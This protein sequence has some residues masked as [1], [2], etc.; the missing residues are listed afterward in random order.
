MAIQG[1]DYETIH[2]MVGTTEFPSELVEEY[3]VRI[4]MLVI[5][6]GGY[7]L[8]PI[9]CVDLCRFVG[10]QSKTAKKELHYI[11]WPLVKIDADIVVTEH[12][13][14]R[15]GKYRGSVQAGRII[16]K[17]ADLDWLSEAVATNV[18]LAVT[19][20]F[21]PKVDTESPS[22]IVAEMNS[23]KDC[24]PSM[25]IRWSMVEV[26]TPVETMAGD[27]VIEYEYLGLAKEKGCLAVQDKVTKHRYVLDAADVFLKQAEPVEV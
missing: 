25:K 15:L 26:G 4:R 14:D 16:V 10:L 11:D 5:A 7:S 8:G 6:G 20:D 21:L 17:F 3:D 22:A 13:V 19:D 24:D 9:G 18:R 23:D 12:G 2:Q 27:D 1:Q